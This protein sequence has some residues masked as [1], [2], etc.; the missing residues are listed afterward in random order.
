[1]LRRLLERP[2][3]LALL[4]GCQFAF[5]AYFS[6]GG[7]RNLTSLFGRAAG[8][9][10]DY[11]RTHD[12]YANLSRLLPRRARP[13]PAQPLP[14]CPERSPFL[15]GPLTV[16]FSRAP[17]LEQIRAKNPAVREGG[18][19]QPPA[20]EARSRTAV[21]IPHRNR[22]THLGHLLYYLHPFLQRQQL[23]YGIYVV[24]QA[25]NSTFNRAKLLNVG[26]KE[27]LKDEEWDCLFLH[28]VDL[29]PE[30]DHNLYTCDPW[31]PK[32]VSI[33][34]NKFGYS[35]PY[36]QYF[37]GVSA[38]T[39][40]QYMKINGFPNEYWGWGGEDDDIATRV[41]LAGM[42]IARPPVSI[43]HYKM[44]KHKSDKGNEENPHRF[45][46]LIR[47]QR[48]WTQDGMN[49]LTYTLLAKHL[50]PL[51]TNLTVDIGTD[52][53]AGRGRG[54]PVPGHE[55]QRYRSSTS[56]FREE[57]LRKLPRDATGW[58]DQGLSLSPWLPTAPAQ[59]PLVRNGTQGSAGSP[60][61]L[62]ST[63]RS[64]EAAGEGDAH[65]G[66][67]TAVAV[68]GEEG[69]LPTRGANQSL[70]QGTR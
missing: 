35:L 52:P 42:K 12:V 11:S 61:A 58:R 48:M 34:M 2:C 70:P 19:Y 28:D 44:V 5:V 17:A 9:V 7:F 6:L 13:D 53:R 3:T 54:G 47:T 25:G 37:G 18:R 67:S 32:H 24:H 40:D 16:S 64:P 59:Q 63:Q 38:L 39:P 20:C 10:F 23:Q 30:N 65:P 57:M 62:G 69:T 21:I 41:R 27:A 55:G 36:P 8:P 15:V 60:P 31:N 4:V 22:E 29:I 1:M 26:V 45:D 50:H 56:L 46:L 51:Y 49:S 68:A 33:A 14:F 66:S 43:G